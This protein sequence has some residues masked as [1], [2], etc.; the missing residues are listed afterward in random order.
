MTQTQL[1]K[2]VGKQI[3][4]YGLGDLLNKAIAFLMMGVS[5]LCHTLITPSPMPMG[6]WGS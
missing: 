4:N 6:N 1:I 5:I 2:N 3:A